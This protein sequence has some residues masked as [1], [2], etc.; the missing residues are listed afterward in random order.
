M[1]KEIC[2]SI[3]SWFSYH[4]IEDNSIL[5]AIN[6]HQEIIF[7]YPIYYSN[8]PKIVRDFIVKNIPYGMGKEFFLLRLWDYL[9]GMELDLVPD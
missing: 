9:V 6:Q 5:E 4:S 1:Y 2:I 7:A 3:C 8:L